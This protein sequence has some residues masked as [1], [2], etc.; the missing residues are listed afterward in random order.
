[1]VLL[2]DGKAKKVL[3]GSTNITKAGIFGHSDVAHVIRDETLAEDFLAYWKK[4]AKDPEADPLQEWTVTANPE[5][6]DRLG[7]EGEELLPPRDSISA[8]FS[9]RQGTKAL[10]WYAQL[11]GQ[12]RECAFLTGPFGVS[13][14]MRDVFAEDRSYLRFLM[15]DNTDGKIELAAESIEKDADNR[16]AVGA[17]LGSGGWNQWLKE[18]LTGFTRKINFIHTKYLLV[19]ALSSDPILVT[20]SA[21]FSDASMNQ[22]DEHM[23]VIRGDTSVADIYLVEYMRLFNAFRLRDRV[24]A[25][26]EKQRA[27]APHTVSNASG[28]LYLHDDDGWVAPYYAEGTPQ[29][30]KR[31]LFSGS[32][33]GR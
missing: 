5:P 19:D 22:N 6:E 1:M 4:L 26:S 7:K 8:V 2:K 29:S 17:Y 27:P 18:H 28:H 30:S 32:W 14:K 23:V 31:E 11:M 25:K 12:A 21:N 13:K 10:K 24:N 20:G 15:L 33:G 16:V 3:A 9:P